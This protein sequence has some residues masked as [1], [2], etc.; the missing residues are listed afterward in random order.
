MDNRNTNRRSTAA[1]RR[2]PGASGSPG[3]F[4]E[5]SGTKG[6]QRRPTGRTINRR[7]PSASARQ[8]AGRV[9]QKSAPRR[10]RHHY[11]FRPKPTFIAAAVLVIAVLVYLI[12]FMV[13]LGVG[14]PRFARGVSI[15]GVS[16]AGLT[17]EEGQ[18]RAEQL[19][20]EWLNT[21]YTFR[22]RDQTWDFT[23]ASID[24]DRSYEPQLEAAWNFGHVGNVFHRKDQID[25][26]RKSPIDLPC[27]VTYDEAKFT[28]FID[29]ICSAID[30][31]AVDAVVV[32]DVLQPVVITESQTGLSVNR[33]LFTEQLKNLVVDDLFDATVPVE[34]VFPAINTDDVGFQIIAQ[35]STDVSFRGPSSRS[36]VRLALES[37]NGLTVMPGEQISFNAVVGPRT[38]ERGYKAA[39]EYAGDTTTM[40]VGGGVCQ[41]ATTLYNALV[42]AGVDVLSRT[43]HSM[44]V[45]YVDPSQDASVNEYGRDL[46]FQNNTE[47]PIFIYSSVSK[48]VASVVIYGHR[49]D[50]FYHL[51]GVVIEKKSRDSRRVYIND[52]E[53]THVYYVDDPPVLQSE[54]RPGCV[55][56]GYIVAYDWDTREEVFRTK[57]SVDNYLPGASV[58]Y[59]GT[60]NRNGVGVISEY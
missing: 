32:P 31:D 24:A 9:P 22:Y 60:H 48:E 33:E 13:I 38:E 25:F 19:E 2:R 34:T 50:Y 5:A 41:A 29:E 57:V 43:Q 40:G 55:S 53:G 49:P 37:F 12:R 47:N 59:R 18:A 8:S 44:T 4:G 27:E 42:M 58:Y 11:R 3:R 28:A 16:F 36:N 6:G 21:V 23:R 17:W 14:T 26:L 45:T 46:I 52:T 54:G 10:P 30:V 1:P 51:E 56:E 39:T 15:D 7:N 35:F 20:Y